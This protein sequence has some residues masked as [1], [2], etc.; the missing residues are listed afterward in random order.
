MSNSII[1]EIR[2]N[3]K[4][5][6][7]WF[8]RNALMRSVGMDLDNRQYLDIAAQAQEDLYDFLMKS[9]MWMETINETLSTAK[10]M[11]LDTKL[12]IDKIYN[13][14]LRS[15]EASKVSEA[16]A[17]AESHPTYITSTKEYNTLTAYVDYLERLLT[18]L[19]KYHYTIKSKIEQ[20]RNIERKY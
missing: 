4:Y 10:K 12:D 20:S 8:D 18:N 15:S 9:L 2:R 17:E 7:I 3:P 14:I 19:D 16:K 1:D 6:I 13:D 11:K 5:K